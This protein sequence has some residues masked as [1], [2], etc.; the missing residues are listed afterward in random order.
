VSC[1]RR[2]SAYGLANVH[3]LQDRAASPRD[4]AGSNNGAGYAARHSGTQSPRRGDRRLDCGVGWVGY[5]T[6]HA[7]VQNLRQSHY[8]LSADLA[9]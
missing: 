8:E 7:F 6:E 1:G 2:T 3:T 4:R 9:T 5:G